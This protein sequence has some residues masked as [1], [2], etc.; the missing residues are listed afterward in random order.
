MRRGERGVRVSFRGS[1]TL[2]HERR[3]SEQIDELLRSRAP[4]TSAAYASLQRAFREW[5]DVNAFDPV[6]CSAKVV[7]AY[8]AARASG[9]WRPARAR[10]THLSPASLRLAAT[11][12]GAIPG[13]ASCPLDV[14]A[15]LR[16]LRTR[17]VA[18]GPRARPEGGHEG[19][20]LPLTMDKWTRMARA[21]LAAGDRGGLVQAA[22]IATAYTAAMRVSELLALRW[23][24]VVLVHA[25]GPHVHLTRE[26]AAPS[27]TTS[28]RIIPLYDVPSH[29]DVGAVVLLRR[30]RAHE[31]ARGRAHEGDIV[32]SDGA[33]QPRHARWF[34]SA[35]QRLALVAKVDGGARITSHGLRAGWATD[36]RTGKAP[37][38]LLRRVGRWSSEKL[39]DGYDRSPASA[40]AQA[41]VRVLGGRF[42]HGGSD[43]R[44][45]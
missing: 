30:L 18:L 8:L 10:A 7:L 33:G 3:V 34:N 23:E 38:E 27:R 32:F 31:V 43:P 25:Q 17:G 19:Q 22:A 39:V 37:P 36:M 1:Q 6:S 28:S 20:A 4:A 35:L 13:R 26:K 24:D 29:A 45:W 16:S 12:I 9:A 14:G 2:P 41:V 40:D 44:V 5:C 11:A 15:L 42:G 21:A